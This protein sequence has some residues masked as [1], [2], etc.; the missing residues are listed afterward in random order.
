MST[1]YVD[2]A[3]NSTGA[4]MPGLAPRDLRHVQSLRSMTLKP[5]FFNLM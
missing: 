3:S 2:A 4:V 1:D 5:G